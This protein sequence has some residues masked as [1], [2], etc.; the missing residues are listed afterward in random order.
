MLGIC[1]Y[2]LNV[3]RLCEHVT[4]VI[5]RTPKS[6]WLGLMAMPDRCRWREK[7]RLVR[8]DGCARLVEVEIVVAGLDQWCWFRFFFL[9]AG[10]G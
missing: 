6:G 2:V 1:V 8:F 9:V 3:V 4:C 5:A 10:G 7:V